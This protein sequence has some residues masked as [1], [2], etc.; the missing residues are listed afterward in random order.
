MHAPCRSDGLAG[1]SLLRV[2][3]ILTMADSYETRQR[4]LDPDRVVEQGHAR[5][6]AEDRLRSRGIWLHSGDDDEGPLFVGWK[7]A[8]R[9]TGCE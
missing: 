4:I 5:Q 6:E 3:D 2:K 7:K 1:R 9:T 8:L